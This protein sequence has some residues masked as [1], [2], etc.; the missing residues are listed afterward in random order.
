M[1]VEGKAKRNSRKTIFL[2]RHGEVLTDGVRRYIGQTDLPLS[3]LG[4]RQAEAW[5][6]FFRSIPLTA[7]FSSDLARTR[8][9]A[10]IVA[11]ERDIALLEEP[12]LREIHLGAWENVPFKTL[13]EQDPAAF[14]ER[15]QHID[16]YRPPGGESF[17][18]LQ[19]RAVAA[20]HRAVIQTD[21]SLL[22]VAHA[23]TNRVI[24]GHILE[25]PL[26]HIFRLAQDHAC[27][28]TLN[29]TDDG[30]RMAG[31]NWAAGGTPP[32]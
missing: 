18:D 3:P 2:M 11:A 23:G 10:A 7:I 20:F 15:G 1:T 6:R 27:L 29:P 24:L 19:R 25:M 32:L 9:T 16:T 14:R 17:R 26:R 4:R 12:D 13:Q 5:Q 30:F 22:I 28:N 31:L 21:G 8:E